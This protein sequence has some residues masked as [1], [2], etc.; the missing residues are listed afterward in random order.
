[1]DAIHV[2]IR[3]G[4][5]A[6][7]P[8]YLAL[9]VTTGGERDILGTVGLG[10]RRRRERQVLAAGAGRDQEPG[11]RDVCMIVCDGLRGLPDAVTAV[12]DKAIV[13]ACIGHLLRGSFRHASRRSLMPRSDS[14]E[15]GVGLG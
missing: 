8:V 9:G 7:R 13:Q 6:N 1:M 2:K 10:A 4:Q 14:G 3:E 5:V 12:C 11:V 15:A